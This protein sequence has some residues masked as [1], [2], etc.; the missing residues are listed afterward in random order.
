M[1]PLLSATQ[2]CFGAITQMRHLD[3][4]SLSSP[5]DL[6]RRLSGFI[7]EMRARLGAAGLHS[8]DVQDITYALVALADEV[9]LNAGEA[10]AGYWMM[11]L[12]QFKYFH[13][14]TAGDGFFSRLSEIRKD[15]RRKD[16]LR[17]YTLC[18]LFGFQGRYR[19]RGGEL[20]LLTLVDSLQREAFGVRSDGEALSPRSRRSADPVRRS[21]QNMRILVAASAAVV[22]SLM[23]NL[24]LRLSLSRSMSSLQGDIAAV[25]HP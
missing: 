19:V 25:V 24:A 14:N 17:V 11:N 8:Q 5:E 13:E 20:E 22:L 15:A 18:L 12:L 4:S 10:L 2:P 7:D 16:V 6:Q 3:P 21:K 1:N 9:A 23:I